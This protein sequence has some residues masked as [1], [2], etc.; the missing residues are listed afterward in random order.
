M[1]R[2]GPARTMPLNAVSPHG[3]ATD[4]NFSAISLAVAYGLFPLCMA[5][6]ALWDL[7]TFT[8]PNKLCIALV[9]S[10]GVAA[11]LAELPAAQVLQHVAT[12]AVVLLI[13]YGLFALRMIGG[14]DGKFLAASALWFG[15]P[16]VWHYAVFFSLAGGLLVILLVILRRLPLPAPLAERDWIARLFGRKSGVPYGVALAAGGL[17]C[18]PHTELFAR[19]IAG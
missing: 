11:F 9:V 18:Y 10:F 19:L 7:R 12:A 15:W 17:L 13:V 4:M 14:G 6:A 5:A 8:I 1:F 16:D 2:K 3:S